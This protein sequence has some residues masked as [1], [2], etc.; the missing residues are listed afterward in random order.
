MSPYLF[1]S[2]FLCHTSNI[3]ISL[4][5]ISLFLL[6]M[7]ILSCLTFLFVAGLHSKVFEFNIYLPFHPTHRFYISFL[8]SSFVVIQ[9]WLANEDISLIELYYLWLLVNCIFPKL[10]IFFQLIFTS[11]TRVA[12]KQR[13]AAVEC[14]YIKT[15]DVSGG[16]Y[17]FPPW[18]VESNRHTKKEIKGHE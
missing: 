12:F 18:I 5:F 10:Y 8:P 1:L 3:L 14:N 2:L 11:K 9:P 6:F 16:I 13:I 7:F 17:L 4:L 15:T